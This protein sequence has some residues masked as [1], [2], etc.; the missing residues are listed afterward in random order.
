MIK[1]FKFGG[2]SVKD[3]SAVRNMARII[4]HYSTSSS[5]LVVVS[6]MGKTTNAL[7]LLY[8]KSLQKDSF[9]EAEN[10]FQNLKKYHFEIVTELFP[11]RQSP[12]YGLFENL[13]QQL[14]SIVSEKSILPESDESYDQIISMG[15]VISTRIV[16]AYLAETGLP[17]LWQD[18]KEYVI[19]DALW[20]EARVDWAT[21]SERVKTRLK[22]MVKEKIVITQGFIGATPDG[23]T[24]TLGREGSDFSAAIFAATLKADSVTIWKDVPGILNAD[25]KRLPNT[26]LYDRLTYREAAEMTYYGAT[27]IHPRTIRP[28]AN[29]GIPLHV[30]SFIE[31][32]QPGTCIE[33]TQPEHMVPAIIFKPDQRLLSF[34]VK[35]FTFIS[36]KNLSTIL[37]ALAKLN[38]KINMMQNSAISFSICID[39]NARKVDELIAQLQPY[40]SI[41]YNENLMLVTIKHYTTETIQQV[42]GMRE[43]V[44]EQKSRHTYQA[45]VTQ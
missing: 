14:W 42:T 25:P 23:R 19:T 9:Q 13:M 6:A 3:A 29:K 28:L 10:L 20:R 11:D 17:A 2:A 41:V 5:L 39:N 15:E 4:G 45:L 40:F 33:A 8:A 36:E 22:P 27:V 32:D 31:S 18:A 30:R 7:E 24:T 21:T 44:L 12:A 38:I 34:A 35:D 1:V 16:A 37:T 26:Q 43:I